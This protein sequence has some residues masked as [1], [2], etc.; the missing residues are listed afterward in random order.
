MF[1]TTDLVPL[2]LL[3]VKIMMIIT[4]VIYFFSSV[5]FL[6]KI[7]LLSRIIETKV[8]SWVAVCALTNVILTALFLLASIFII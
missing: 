6:Q 8:S 5:I 7:R 4:F 1:N 2:V 3:G